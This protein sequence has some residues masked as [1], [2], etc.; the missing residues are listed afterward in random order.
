MNFF[1]RV[2][3]SG[4]LA[5]ITIKL[6]EKPLNC[7]YVSFTFKAVKVKIWFLFLMAWGVG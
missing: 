5:K 6:T 7:K 4:E 3:D 2:S 1:M